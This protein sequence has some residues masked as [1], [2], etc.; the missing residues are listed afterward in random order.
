VSSRRSRRLSQDLWI[1]RNARSCAPSGPLANPHCLS[2]SGRTSAFAVIGERL[3]AVRKMIVSNGRRAALQVPPR[4]GPKCAPKRP[5]HCEPERGFTARNTHSSDSSAPPRRAESWMDQAL[6]SVDRDSASWLR[7]SL[8][9][10]SIAG[11]TIASPSLPP[12]NTCGGFA[13]RVRSTSALPSLSGL[14]VCLPS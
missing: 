5:F 3:S 12:T 11:K 6:M 13:I 10:A 7:M 2:A 4:E 9:R 1:E 8:S 14:P